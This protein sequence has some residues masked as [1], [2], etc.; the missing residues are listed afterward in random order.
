[1]LKKLTVIND[2]DF[3]VGIKET[4]EACCGLGN[5]KANIPCIPVSTYCTN[6]SDHLFWDLVHPTEMVSHMFVDLLY[7]GSRRYMHPINV[8]MLVNM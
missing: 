7:S 8:Q 2:Y 4:K 6:R 3:I 5:L 1:M